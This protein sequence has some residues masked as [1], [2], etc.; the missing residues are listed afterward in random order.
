[1]IIPSHHQLA[2]ITPSAKLATWHIYIYIYI[3][4]FLHY[5]GTNGRWNG[6]LSICQYTSGTFWV[7]MV[8]FNSTNDFVF[9][10]LFS[11]HSLPNYPDHSPTNPENRPVIKP[12]NHVYFRQYKRCL[13][14]F[15][16]PWKWSHD[17]K[18]VSVSMPFMIHSLCNFRIL[19]SRS[20]FPLPKTQ[21]S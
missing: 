19:F 21:A 2:C 13:F 8:I 5:L 4:I 10:T 7:A 15:V 1:L 12:K 3:Y 6:K 17:D 20:Q 18:N 16:L 9:F 14:H 11:H